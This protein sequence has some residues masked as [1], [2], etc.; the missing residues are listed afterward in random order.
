MRLDELSLNPSS[1]DKGA[2]ASR[3]VRGLSADSRTVQPGY[4]FAA[5]PGTKVDGQAFISQAIENGATAVLASEP[6]LAQPLHADVAFVT[7]D[8]PHRDLAHMAARFFEFQPAHIGCITGTNGKTSTASFLRQLLATQG[9]KAAAIGTLGVEADGYFE[10]LQHTTPDPVRLHAALRDLSAH[11]VTHLAMEASS[12]G[13]AQHRMDGVRVEV[14]GFTNLSRDH[15]D[16]HD[17]PE[18]YEAAKQRLFTELLSETGTAVIVGS[19]AS[20]QRL[21]AVC[22]TSGRSVVMVGRPEDSVFVRV[23]ARTATGLQLD[24]TLNGQS[25]SLAVPLIGDFQT[26]NLALALG[27]AQAFGLQDTELFSACAH[28]QAPRGRMQFVGRSQNGASLYVDYAHTPDALDNALEALRAHLPKDGKL[29]VLFGCGGNRD[30]GKRPKMGKVAAAKADSIFVTDDN[31][32]Q[33]E[34]ASIR[35]AILAA[36]PEAQEIGDRG[37]AI[38]AIINAAQS[39]DIVLLAGKGH[40]SG[41]IIGDT[42]LPFD[43]AMVAQSYLSAKGGQHG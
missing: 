31:P 39:D 24:I 42:I 34:A 43:D 38:G 33:E 28:L 7:S 26:E 23:A 17:T 3:D 32:R 30:A 18:A 14:A 29:L 8:N 9:H 16:Y 36:C 41:Q 2:L 22:Q 37:E 35:A 10:P 5:L 27:M 13:L 12:H 11:G 21:Q 25:Q 4:L 1:K 19:H 15:L 40:E 20:G 6:L